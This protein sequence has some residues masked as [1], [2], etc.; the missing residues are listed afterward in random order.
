MYLHKIKGQ[1]GK[2]VFLT[3]TKILPKKYDKFP[4]N[5]QITLSTYKLNCQNKDYIYKIKTQFF[6]AKKKASL[7]VRSA[8]DETSIYKIVFSFSLFFIFI[9]PPFVFPSLSFCCVKSLKCMHS[10]LQGLQLWL[11]FLFLEIQIW[12]IRIFL[13]KLHTFFFF[14][15]GDK[16]HTWSIILHYMSI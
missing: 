9:F 7:H 11:K 13:D 15:I 8:C 2:N 6:F 1:F 5:F 4:V 3:S 14:L 16:L 10:N 12:V